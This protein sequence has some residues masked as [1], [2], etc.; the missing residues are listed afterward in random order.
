MCVRVFIV[1]GFIGLFVNK[2]SYN[3]DLKETLKSNF[4]LSLQGERKINCFSS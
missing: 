4:P 2:R 1:G 3:F